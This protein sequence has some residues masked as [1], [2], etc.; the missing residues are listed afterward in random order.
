MEF[1]AYGV[2]YS[3]ITT[4]R[5]LA[6]DLRELPQQAWQHTYLQH[7][8]QVGTPWPEC[9]PSLLDSAASNVHCAVHRCA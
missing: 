6:M 8:L 3:A 4:P 9:A 5:Q 7:A 2:L 1:L